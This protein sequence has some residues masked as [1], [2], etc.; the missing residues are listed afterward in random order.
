MMHSRFKYLLPLALNRIAIILKHLLIQSNRLSIADMGLRQNELSKTTNF[1][2]RM[3]IAFAGKQ[4]T[5]NLTT[6]IRIYNN[7]NWIRPI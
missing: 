3:N 7:N 5:D 4:D 6:M 2:G 1:I